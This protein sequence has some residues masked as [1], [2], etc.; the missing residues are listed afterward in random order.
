MTSTK[1]TGKH[2]CLL[3]RFLF[4]FSRR[5]F[6]IRLTPIARRILVVTLFGLNLI[7]GYLAML[8]A[9]TYSIELFT[10]VVLGLCLGHLVFN[11]KSAVGESIDPCCA[12]QQGPSVAVSNNALNGTS[13]H[14]PLTR[15]PCDLEGQIDSSDNEEELE[16]TAPASAN[17]VKCACSS[18][19][20]QTTSENEE[21]RPPSYTQCTT[22]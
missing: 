21:K 14:V 18:N 2:P 4:R 3:T 16:P 12:S 13:N 8:V 9:M 11:T 7:G 15:T 17:E 22:W 20:I 1:F 10:C 5:G 6:V 19:G